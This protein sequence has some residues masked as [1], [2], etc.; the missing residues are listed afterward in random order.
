MIT[1]CVLYSNKRK[2]P[3]MGLFCFPAPSPSRSA[4]TRA[5]PHAAL[6]LPR[7][8][9]IADARGGVRGAGDVPCD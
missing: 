7:G 8:D 5:M 9:S 2:P 6:R 3:S 4:E 1:H